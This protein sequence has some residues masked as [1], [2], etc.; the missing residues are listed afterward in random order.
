MPK[1]LAKIELEGDGATDGELVRS[2]S[3]AELDR[4]RL[5]MAAGFLLVVSGILLT[6][7][8]GGPNPADSAQNVKLFGLSLDFKNSPAALILIAVG[9]LLLFFASVKIR[10]NKSKNGT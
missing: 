3:K 10:V 9:A 6:L 8:G 4:F 1:K 2:A 7:L 5:C